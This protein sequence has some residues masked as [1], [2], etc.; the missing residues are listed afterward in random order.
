MLLWA[1]EEEDIELDGELYP[2]GSDELKA[3]ALA[4]VVENCGAGRT[5][6]NPFNRAW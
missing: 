5:S 3:G 2:E 1:E 6:T 4:E